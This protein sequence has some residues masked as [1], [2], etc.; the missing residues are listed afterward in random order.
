MKKLQKRKLGNS[1]L[2]IA[3]EAIEIFDSEEVHF[4]GDIHGTLFA[5]KIKK[6][7][8]SVWTTLKK[9]NNLDKIVSELSGFFEKHKNIVEEILCEFIF[10]IVVNIIDEPDRPDGEEIKHKIKER[11]TIVLD[12]LERSR[13]AFEVKAPLFRF[14]SD[15]GRFDFGNSIIRYVGYLEREIYKPCYPEAV[16]PYGSMEFNWVMELACN[17]KSAIITGEIMSEFMTL[18]GNIIMG[19]RLLCGGSAGIEY[20]DIKVDES[21]NHHEIGDTIQMGQSTIPALRALRPGKISSH[22]SK[23]AAKDFLDFMKQ[24]GTLDN[25]NYDFIWRTLRRYGTALENQMTEDK[26]IDLVISLE[27]LLGGQR[28]EDGAK[29]MAIYRAA[30]LATTEPG[31]D[32]EIKEML[33]NCWDARHVLVHGGSY[34]SAE[35]RAKGNLADKTNRLMEIV[36]KCILI[37]VVSNLGEKQD[38]WKSIDRASESDTSKKAIL[39]NI[40]SWLIRLMDYV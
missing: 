13:C 22:L 38:Y 19:I 1:I 7:T 2:E 15:A 6:D 20:L 37:S 39:M 25:S 16:I 23:I 11:A 10:D 12:E 9:S 14:T 30:T 18:A 34:E 28:D 17:S 40:P 36:R 4:G 32:S 24:L 31:I 5:Q 21:V 3:F 27:T 35:K 29:K 8:T 26:L 33:E